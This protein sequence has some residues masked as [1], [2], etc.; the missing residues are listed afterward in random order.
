MSGRPIRSAGSP[1]AQED[2]AGVGMTKVSQD[3]AAD[4]VGAQH[5]VL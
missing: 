1:R 2:P 5:E 3:I 4:I